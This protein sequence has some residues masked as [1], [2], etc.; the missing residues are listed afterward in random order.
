MD[1][2]VDVATEL[3]TT[4]MDNMVEPA[5]FECNVI[6]HLSYSN[7]SETGTIA[8]TICMMQIMK[9]ITVQGICTNQIIIHLS[10]G[11]MYTSYLVLVSVEFTKQSC[12]DILGI[13]PSTLDS[14]G[15][16]ST[17]MSNLIMI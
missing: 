10:P 4:T 6:I 9:D 14:L 8:S 5:N 15:Q 11:P 13:S 2:E 16:Q 12:L 3:A 1:K 7:D 17:N